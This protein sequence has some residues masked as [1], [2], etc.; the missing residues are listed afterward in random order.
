MLPGA[1]NTESRKLQIRGYLLQTAIDL[2]AFERTNLQIR[3]GN[4]RLSF[5]CPLESSRLFRGI[6][7][8]TGDWLGES[9]WSSL[10]KTTSTAE[11]LRKQKATGL[12]KKEQAERRRSVLKTS[13]RALARY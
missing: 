5:E 13:E 6:I 4:N 3:F 2:K 8:G 10:H 12:R 11:Q 7:P 9:S 1:E